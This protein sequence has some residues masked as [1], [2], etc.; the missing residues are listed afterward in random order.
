MTRIIVVRS[1]I[2]LMKLYRLYAVGEAVA[3]PSIFC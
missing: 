1:P 3:T 2:T